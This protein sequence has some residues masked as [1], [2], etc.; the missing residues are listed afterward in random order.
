MS[1][2]SALSNRS[3]LAFAILCLFALPAPA[4]EPLTDWTSS[5]FKSHPLVGTVWSADGR[6][7]T[8]PDLQREAVS[9]DIV[10]LGE[11]HD[12]PDHHRLQS[13]MLGAL[14]TS[15]RRPAV[16]FEMIPAGYQQRL[17]AFLAKNPATAEGLGAQLDWEKRGWPNWQSYRPIADRALAGG[18]KILAGDLDRDLIRTISRKGRAALA[19]EQQARLMLD[20]DLPE[21]ASARLKEILQQSHCNLLPEQA[22]A[23]MILV[24]RA[25]DGALA[26]ALLDA[27]KSGADGAVL[28]AGAGHV[29]RDLAVP[30]ILESAKPAPRTLA[31]AFIE[32][33]EA[34]VAATEYD[35]LEN[36]DFVVFTPRADLTDHC[37]ELAEQMKAKPPANSD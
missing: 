27:L 28:I 2:Q 22:I 35:V 16:I 14:V 19:P 3:A 13:E 24:Q 25:R 33:D 34:L 20:G 15:G 26:A 5:H 18:L 36:Y 1:A 32:V 31:I 6:P 9:A 10:L 29:R 4:A 30:R 17:D 11:I 37:A 12:N 21:A 8:W 7:A 23:P